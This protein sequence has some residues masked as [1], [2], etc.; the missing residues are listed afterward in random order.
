MQP[1]AMSAQ[2]D[3]TATAPRSKELLGSLNIDAGVPGT[4][5]DSSPLAVDVS[6][7]RQQQSELVSL[8]PTSL[9]QCALELSE[10]RQTSEPETV[11]YGTLTLEFTPVKL[12]DQRSR[13]NQCSASSHSSTS[14]TQPI[15]MGVQHQETSANNPGFIRVSSEDFSAA[16]P[17]CSSPTWHLTAVGQPQVSRKSALKQP[18]SPIR[19][20]S[21]AGAST[22]PTVAALDSETQLVSE[23]LSGEVKPLAESQGSLKP[24]SL[25]SGSE[26]PWRLDTMRG[27]L[28]AITHASAANHEQ[29]VPSESAIRSSG[30]GAEPD[31]PPLGAAEADEAFAAPRVP[32]A[33]FI[34]MGIHVHAH[35]SYLHRHH[36]E[37]CASVAAILDGGHWDRVA[38]AAFHHSDVVHLTSNMFSFFFKGL[39]LETALGPIHF[40]SVLATAVV[41]VGLLSAL[42]LLM[43]YEVTSL[44]HVQVMCM[45]TFAGVI[46][47]LEVLTRKYFY[48]SRIHYG[49]YEFGLRP[50]AFVLFELLVLYASSVNNPLPMISGLVA[51]AFLSKTSLGKFITRIQYR[52][53]HIYF[54]VL[55]NAPATFL[56]V[57]SIIVAFLYGPYS[58]P[59]A[60]AG[61]AV[62]FRHPVWQ[63]PILPALYLSNAYQLAYVVLTLLAVGQELERDFG[64]YSFLCLAFGLLFTVN[65]L[66]D[67]LS[68]ILWKYLTAFRGDFPTPVPLSSSC[69]AGLVG[70]LLAMKIIHQKR[71]PYRDY[72]V[73][74]FPIP[75]PFWTC[76]PLELAHLHLFMPRGSTVDHVTGVLL[77][78]IFT[79]Y[80]REA[81]AAD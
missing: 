21:S 65:V 40:A 68:W 13:S 32:W 27:T 48:Y 18:L 81:P 5:S 30:Q 62:V 79:H 64:H 60:A 22:L 42:A 9:K 58:D 71:H 78:L 80:Y 24:R 20:L 37:R 76:V 69:S 31:M 11:E 4:P 43:L 44:S 19:I 10:A 55:P 54:C 39:L 23:R 12:S 41:M 56:F 46:V 28:G 75:M 77:G 61:S 63:P 67:G 1:S 51:G 25:R 8:F 45:H 33:T 17:Q 66:Q 49:K 38:F 26:I 50:L 34:T 14:S 59:S 7:S 15:S 35:W 52:R 16:H 53:R 47:C 6:S 72:Q 57:A 70:T 3:V 29:V 73:A 74:S 36:A 2:A